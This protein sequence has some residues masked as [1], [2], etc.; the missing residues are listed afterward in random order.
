MTHIKKAFGALAAVALIAAAAFAL[1][2]CGDDDDD[3]SGSGPTSPAATA[4]TAGAAQPPRPA[5]NTILI[6]DN[7][8]T[9]NSLTVKAGEKVTWTWGGRNPHSVAGSF[10]GQ[11]VVSGQ[12]SSGNFDFTFA[13]AG[14]FNYFCG[15][16]GELMPGKVI[17]Q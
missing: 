2:A 12:Q 4:T 9:P 8:F 14:T 5:G 11:T 16:H 17:V 10:E 15:V 13:K 7:K 1:A 6:E 3:A